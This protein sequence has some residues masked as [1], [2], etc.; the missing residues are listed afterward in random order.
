LSDL[1]KSLKKYDL[2]IYSPRSMLDYK[3]KRR[4]EVN[5]T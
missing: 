2:M 1:E 4:R 5:G 3:R